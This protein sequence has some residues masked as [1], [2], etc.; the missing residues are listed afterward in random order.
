MIGAG[1]G[2]RITRSAGNQSPSQKLVEHRLQRIQV[3]FPGLIDVTF[4]L[5]PSSREA[6]QPLTVSLLVYDRVSND[7][8]GM[9]IGGSLL[10]LASL[11]AL[12]GVILLLIQAIG[13]RGGA[14]L[15]AAEEESDDS[16]E[17]S[18]SVEPVAANLSDNQIRNIAMWCHLSAL[19]G[20]LVPM[21]NLIGPLVV[22]LTQR[23]KSAFIDDQGKEAINF[24]LS[25]MVYA[26][27]CFLLILILVGFLLLLALSFGALALVIIAALQANQGVAYRYPLIIRF[28]R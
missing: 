22:W 11:L 4:E 1:R 26:A 7:V 23:D 21:G 27:V 14:N 15:P 8:R 12:F 19:A 28:I 24:Q 6:T 20:L 10:V 17:N 25:V 3:P 13:S 18:P 2:A 5:G 16:A 9:I